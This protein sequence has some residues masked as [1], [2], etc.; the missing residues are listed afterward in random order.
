MLGK[1]DPLDFVLAENLGLSLGQV[2]DLPNAEHVEWRAFF[3]YRHEMEKLH[4]R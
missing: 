2:R 4:G 3:K 1:L